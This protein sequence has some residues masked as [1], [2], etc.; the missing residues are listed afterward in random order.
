MATVIIPLTTDPN[1]TFSS[2]IP[3]NGENKTF[4][5]F[6]RFN[7]EANYW[8]MDLSDVNKNPIVS[9]IPLITGINILEQYEYLHIGKAYIVKTDDS[10]LA[11]KP[12]INNLGDTFKLVWTNND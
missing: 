4:Y 7:E 2:T 1:D 5:F 11:D 6:L 9:S 8:V 12:D 3:V 10:L